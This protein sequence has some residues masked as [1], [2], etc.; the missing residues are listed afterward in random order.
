MLMIANL[1]DEIEFA[2]VNDEGF[3]QT[4]E[5]PLFMDYYIVVGKEKAVFS[6]NI[7][8]FAMFSSKIRELFRKLRNENSIS[9]SV[10]YPQIF[11]DD[12]KILHE[13][14]TRG[15]IIINR[16]N[17]LGTL[18]MAT[19]FEIEV[20]LKFLVDYVE[21]NEEYID[22]L[23]LFLFSYESRSRYLYN[24]ALARIK[25]MGELPF[26]SEKLTKYFS[27]EALIKMISR[28]R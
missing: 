11:V 18:K 5:D 12:F 3:K 1:D 20:L 4:M 17:I 25:D 16:Q 7:T 28:I 14:L 6:V 9:E 2:L 19:F 21:R 10:E 23:D 8:F 26:L 24:I 13:L 22:R 27:E 15:K